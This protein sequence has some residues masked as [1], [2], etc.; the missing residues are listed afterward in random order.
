MSQNSLKLNNELKFIEDSFKAGIITKE[1]YDTA[2]KRV[3]EKIEQAKKEEEKERKLKEKHPEVIPLNK[4][5]EKPIS[6]EK[7]A[8][9][10]IK[11]S[12]T[13]K[14]IPTKEKEQP[15]EESSRIKLHTYKSDSKPKKRSTL[16]VLISAIIIILIFLF[17]SFS[18][19]STDSDIDEPV[20]FADLDCQKTGF[21]G[22]CL[23]DSTESAEC[24]FEPAIPVNITIITS[25]NC[26]LCDT[27]R[28]KNTLIQ[29]YPSAKYETLELYESRD[30]VDSLDIEALPAY[31]IEESIEKTKRFE[32]TRSMLVKKDEFYLVKPSASGASY[33]FNNDEKSNDVA[34]FIYPFSSSSVKAFNNLLGLA[35][36]RD[37]DLEIMYYTRGDID[38]RN[39]E[40]YEI[41][42][43]LCI[44]QY[45]E[46]K[47]RSYLE[48][49]F[50]QEIT[51]ES[52]SACLVENNLPKSTIEACIDDESSSL[53]KKD[54]AKASQFS[55]NTVPS[56]IFNN[57]YKKGGSL[58]VDILDKLF[59]DT[60]PEEC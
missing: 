20:C 36:E 11:P 25:D 41:L 10:E 55:I 47:F 34:L 22:K 53:L 13:E 7:T 21:V 30:L 3:E 50:Q 54:I 18:P 16:L 2:K 24:V 57:Q 14:E 52:A 35:D 42:Q 17:I 4:E 40:I 19:D 60:N 15:K 37:I 23:N 49:I 26:V 45:S 46:S 56:F 51:P 6:T 48:C 58:S 33:F 32:S 5:S 12:S 31:I 27:K 9:Q 43:Q 28:M 29:I 39:P 38:K 1:E 8:E 44:R 59:C